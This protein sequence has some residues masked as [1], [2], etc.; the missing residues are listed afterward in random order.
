MTEQIRKLPWG[1]A[2]ALL[3]LLHAPSSMAAPPTGDDSAG[4]ANQGC[5]HGSV[6]LNK[7]SA[8]AEKMFAIVDTD[9]DGMIT[10]VEF[11]AAEPPRH[12]RNRGMRPP[13][14]APHQGPMSDPAQRQA[15]ETEVFKA[16]DS[17]GNGEL[18]SAEF[19]QIHEVMQV[20]MRK[21]AFASLDTNGD[22]TLDKD[23]FPPMKKH[24]A[25]MDSDG[26][27]TVTRQEMRAAKQPPPK[28]AS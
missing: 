5:Q 25:A 18:S 6:D 15:L 9:S 12:H 11:L 1:A 16:L 7:V 3:A 10:E 2:A 21:Q 27:G 24:M 8:R 23:E 28:P 17:D 26:D 20:T 13:M 19:A 22:G 4:A 14:G